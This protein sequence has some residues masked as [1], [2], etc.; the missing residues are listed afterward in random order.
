MKNLSRSGR[1]GLG[2]EQLR[3]YNA[4]RDALQ[5]QYIDF[6]E[7]L[8]IYGSDT[9]ERVRVVYEVIHRFGESEVNVPR[10]FIDEVLRY[11]NGY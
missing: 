10:E 6:V 5:K 9:P 1:L 11:V 3:S 4:Q 7:E 8:G 2:A